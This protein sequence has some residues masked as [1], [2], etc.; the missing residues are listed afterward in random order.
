LVNLKE[1][2]HLEDL[3]VDGRIIWNSRKWSGREWTG[4]IWLRIGTS[5]ALV[6]RVPQKVEDF[7][8]AQQ[9]LA[10]QEEL[11]FLEL[12]S[13]L[14]GISKILCVFMTLI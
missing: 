3:G 5:G 2:D 12:V 10:S 14:Y 8:L 11:C 6:L 4:F 13:S 9:L 1:R 7:L